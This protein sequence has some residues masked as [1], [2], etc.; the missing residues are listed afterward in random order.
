VGGNGIEQWQR[1]RQPEQ[2]EARRAEILHA[3]AEDFEELGLERMT[4]NGLARRAG[5]AKSNLYRYF[6]SLEEILLHLFLRDFDALLEDLGLT[7]G[8]GGAANR[9]K[10]GAEN[11]AK[12]RAANRAENR[13]EN[14]TGPGCPER[15][16]ELIAQ[17]VEE[18]PRFAALLAELSGVM[19]RPLSHEVADRFKR[20]IAARATQLSAW[21]RAALPGLGPDEAAQAIL[22]MHA[23]I[24]GYWPMARPSPVMEGVL[25]QPEL[26]HLRVRFR[27]AFAA[28]L[29]AYLRGLTSGNA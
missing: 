8:A 26:Q 25:A 19:E 15:L 12:N 27:P 14:A 11:E 5:Q 21:M 13:A 1:A 18:H 7:V 28:T 29:A 24:A 9:A 20:E 10:N 2:K 6:E 4:L 23:M 22:A 3:A 16:A 17:R